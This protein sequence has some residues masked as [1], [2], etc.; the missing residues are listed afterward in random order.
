MDNKETL[1]TI[2]WYVKTHWG[3]PT[4]KQTVLNLLAG[5]LGE[6]QP[7]SAPVAEKPADT[8]PVSGDRLLWYPS[9]QRGFKRS[10]TRG[11][12]KDAYPKG[13]IVHFTAGRHEGLDTGMS[14]QVKDG[15]T[16]FIIDKDGNVG[17]NFPLSEWGYH[18]G[19]SSWP[20]LVEG[21]SDELVGIEVQCPGKLVKTGDTYKTWYGEAVAPED[22]RVVKTE[23]N[24]EGGAY[25]KYTE[26]QE[27]ALIHL[28][29]WLRKNNPKVFRYD[30]VLGHDEVSPGRKNDPGGSLSMPMDELR[31]LLA[32]GT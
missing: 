4:L 21:V 14:Q 29:R 9:A 3:D 6:D 7:T 22:V 12:Y 5:A 11:N 32:S 26:A 18:A 1:Y 20:G 31:T 10:I 19:R 25:F 30:L 27:T 16:Y 8:A 17:Q 24:M 13:A 28:L 15:F 23:K 2:R